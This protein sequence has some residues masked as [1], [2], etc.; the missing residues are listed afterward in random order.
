MTLPSPIEGV[1]L[2]FRWDFA[3]TL[4][5]ERP[6]VVRW[7]E[8]SPE[9]FIGRGGLFPAVLRDCAARWP[10]VTHGLT[11]S[12]AG[13]DALSPTYLR[14]L[15]S[16]LR[17][18]QVP[19]HSEHLCWS[20]HGG[21]ELHELLPVPRAK[22]TV[23]RVVDRLRRAQ[24]AVGV[25]LA[26]ENITWYA[27][28]PGSTMPEEDFLCEVLQRADAKLLLDVNNVYVNARNHG[29]D[30]RR[31]LRAMPP[32]RVVQLHVA[33]H[34]LEPDGTRIDT[35][36]AP[37]CEEVYEL[38]KYTLAH[39]GRVPILLERDHDIP[40]LAELVAEA[41]RLDALWREAPA[42]PA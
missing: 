28:P 31:F 33:G 34:T 9:N 24:D 17:D 18:A 11:L 13:W 10:V 19:W 38:V 23:A 30:A 1:G 26:I 22:E 37:V 6:D 20:A 15:R 32:E 25:P 41:S 12:I 42:R 4:L 7:L 2:G 21:V 14:A 8:V 39:V 27:S 5:A 29:L 40:A 35:H 16:F 3:Q 36:G